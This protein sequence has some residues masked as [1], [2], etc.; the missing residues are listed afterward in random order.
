MPSV[1]HS[2]IKRLVGAAL[3]CLIVISL[4]LS[5]IALS[6][7][8]ASSSMSGDYVNDT[9]S[10]AQSLQE[11]I[12]LPKEAEE[13]E[14]AEDQALKLITNYISRYRNR[15]KVNKSQS[16][17]TMQTALNSMAGHYKTF[18]NRPLPEALKERLNKELSK[19][20]K[21]VSKGS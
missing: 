14:E 2:L 20:E 15:S 4:I 5:P 9:I 12:A 18:A 6:A 13:R 16:F 3:S 17:T 21:L 7:N 8:A 11:T 19:A 1:F 10:V